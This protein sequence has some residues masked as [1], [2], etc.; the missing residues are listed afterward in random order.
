MPD[1]AG[2]VTEPTPAPE[3]P[4]VSGT[5][6]IETLKAEYEERIKGFQRLVSEKERAAMEAQ[7]AA[8][9]A[10]LAALPE[11][12]RAE[13]L[14]KKVQQELSALRTENELL[15]LRSD[16]GDVM[17][18]Y[19]R[20]LKAPTAKDQLELLR[21]LMAQAQPASAPTAPSQQASEPA[22]VDMNNPMRPPV[23]GVTLSDGTVM[24]HEIADR[25]LN[26]FRILRS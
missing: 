3:A 6:D 18:A 11:D 2:Q 10:R 24:D 15:R 14:D 7:R 13:I 16:Y 21:G 23:E 20:I 25:I 8:E 9:E 22:P 19:D 26:S 12:E 17:D 4:V 1:L 5:P